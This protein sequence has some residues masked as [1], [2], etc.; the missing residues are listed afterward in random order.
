MRKQK[1][2]QLRSTMTYLKYKKLSRGLDPHDL[3]IYENTKKE[4]EFYEKI[5]KKSLVITQ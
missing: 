5:M 3:K 4:L 2:E 1:I